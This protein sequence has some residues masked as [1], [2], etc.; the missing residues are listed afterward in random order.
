MGLFWD[1]EDKR[2]NESE[3]VPDGWREL[4][5]KMH[6]QEEKKRKANEQFEREWIEDYMD[7]K[8]W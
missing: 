4:S 3:A 6:L 5:W 1:D 7:E 8:G 2:K